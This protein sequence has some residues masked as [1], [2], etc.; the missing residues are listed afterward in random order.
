[1]KLRIGQIAPNFEQDT[2]NGSLRFHEWIQGAWCLLFSCPSDQAAKA[3]PVALAS[4]TE[5]TRRG[6]EWK[7]R[8]VKLIGLGRRSS[9]GQARWQE[10]L[11]RSHDLVLNFPVVAD[12]DRTVS[13]LYRIQDADIETDP[14]QEKCHVL[15]IDPSRKIRLARTY[16]AAMGCDFVSLQVAIDELQRA[17]AHQTEKRASC[18]GTETAASYA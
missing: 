13:R 7:Q 1:V 5:A 2:G 4:L 15:V 9:D 8:N 16:P 6:P 17:D 14:A 18:S 11:A 12:A 3:S 10:E